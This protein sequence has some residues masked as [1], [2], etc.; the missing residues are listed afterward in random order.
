MSVAPLFSAAIAAAAAIATALPGVAVAGPAESQTILLT[1]TGA[2]EG[3]GL[4]DPDGRG[5]AELRIDPDTG[6]FCYVVTVSDIAP[7]VYTHVHNAPAGV[8]GGPIVVQLEP[9]SDGSSEGCVAIAPELARKL[10]SS[11]A[12]YYLNVHNADHPGGAIRAQLG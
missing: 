10:I 4:G 3:P 1:L 12:D 9:P 8:G 6:Q 2:A 11:P 5:T 7:A